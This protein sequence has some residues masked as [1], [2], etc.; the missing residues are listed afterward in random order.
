MAATKQAILPIRGKD[1][2][3]RKARLDR[4]LS[5]DTIRSLITA[6]DGDENF[7][8][9]KLRCGLESSSWRTPIDG[10]RIATLLLDPPLPRHASSSRWPHLHCD[11]CCTASS[12]QRRRM[13]SP[14]RQG[15]NSA[16]AAGARRERRHRRWHPAPHR[17]SAQWCPNCGNHH[18]SRHQI[19]SGSPSTRLQT[20]TK[21]SRSS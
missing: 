6:F 3:R 9:S 1:P 2:Q 13:N 7:D 17:A 14:T 21:P 18:G 5:S 12:G 16:F 10:Q 20:P 11:T 4:A 8:I 15:Q 19:I